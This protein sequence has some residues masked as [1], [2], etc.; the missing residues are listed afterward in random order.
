MSRHRRATRLRRILAIARK[1][2]YQR[3][4]LPIESIDNTQWTRVAI[5]DE[6]PAVWPA[7]G[8]YMVGEGPL[9][10]LDPS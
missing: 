5:P 3:T 2:A 1:S 7:L 4:W 6:P 9:P 10:D 8:R